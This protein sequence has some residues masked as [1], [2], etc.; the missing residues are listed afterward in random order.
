[1]PNLNP[2]KNSLN[3]KLVHLWLVRSHIDHLC[4]QILMLVQV[5]HQKNNYIKA[6]LMLCLGRFIQ[7]KDQ[8]QSNILKLALHKL[9]EFLQES[10]PIIPHRLLRPSNAL[11]YQMYPKKYAYNLNTKKNNYIGEYIGG[12]YLKSKKRNLYNRKKHTHKKHMF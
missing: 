2:R 11:L 9:Q 5:Q 3:L 6:K 10:S 1:M 8:K 7:K 4:Y 12:S